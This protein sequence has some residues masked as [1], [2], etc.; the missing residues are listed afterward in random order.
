MHISNTVARLLERL[1]KLKLWGQNAE[2]DD[3]TRRSLRVKTKIQKVMRRIARKSVQFMQ[4]LLAVE[5]GFSIVYRICLLSFQ[6]NF[7]SHE[8]LLD[9]PLRTQERIHEIVGKNLFN[10]V[11]LNVQ[12]IVKKTTCIVPK[13][14]SG[15]LPFQIIKHQL[16]AL[17]TEDFLN[18]VRKFDILIQFAN[19]LISPN[20]C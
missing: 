13:V 20:V 2:D 17:L 7:S 8:L 16:I 15:I 6:L 5:V 9:L 19:I 3:N 14:L 11:L 1:M 10:L 18:W 12:K 4:L